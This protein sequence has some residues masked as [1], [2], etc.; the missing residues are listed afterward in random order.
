MINSYLKS[1]LLAIVLGILVSGCPTSKPE[2]EGIKISLKQN[3][4]GYQQAYE[5]AQRAIELYPEDPEVWFYWGYLNGEYKKDYQTMNEAYDKVLALN[6]NAKI[7]FKGRSV[8]AK[9]LIT[10]ERNLKFA[11][12]YNTAVKK[13]NVAVQTEDEAEK[14]KLLNEVRDNLEMAMQISPDRTEPIYLL[15]L[16][17][18]ELGETEK[19][20]PLLEKAV[21]DHPKDVDVLLG[22][23]DIYTRMD[24]YDKAIDMF[25]K[26]LEVDPQN[27]N[28]YKQLGIL[29]GLRENW[30]KSNEFYQKAMELDPD[31]ADLA[32]NIGVSYYNQGQF[33]EAIPYFK[34][35]LEAE[36]DNETTLKVLA[37]CYVRSDKSEEAVEFMEKTVEMY[38]DDPTMWEYLAIVYGK[39]GMKDKAEEAFNK[40]KEL[41]GE[42]N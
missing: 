18:L 7:S 16:A 9:D 25:K 2:V 15:S 30:A 4:P 31:N 34:K 41:K 1:T 28:A 8:V 27:S 19:I 24:N 17:Y 26:V 3:P 32:Y 5:S 13:Q 14:K 11:E 33:D 40:S 37:S 36:P 23:G 21:A 12:S 38:P 20:D 22:A 39:M 6:P 29:E 42:G 35:S 10:T